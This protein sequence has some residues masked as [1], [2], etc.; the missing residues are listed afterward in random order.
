MIIA[1]AM[2]SRVTQPE[3]K[4]MK[5]RRRQSE[6]DHFL[7]WTGSDDTK[8]GKNTIKYADRYGPQ[9]EIYATAPPP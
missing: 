9:A 1:T 7:A 8:Y 4:H 3:Q 5:L 2:S 6:V